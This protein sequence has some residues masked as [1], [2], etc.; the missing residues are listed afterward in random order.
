MN[1]KQFYLENYP[2]DELGI[3]LK[4]D[5]NF[6]GLLNELITN[7]DVYGYIGVGDSII[8]ERLFMELSEILKCSYDYV[9][10]LWLNN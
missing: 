3:E 1:I 5:T 2:T 8:R 7:N 10:N 4:D 9:Y 6:T